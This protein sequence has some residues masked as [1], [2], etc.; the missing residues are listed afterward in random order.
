MFIVI[1]N[2]S[3]GEV[4]IAERR[5]VGRS[6]S[7]KTRA[8]VLSEVDEVMRP[9]WRRGFSC[10]M[11]LC[12]CTGGV[13][14]SSMLLPMSDHQPI[15]RGPGSFIKVY[16]DE[17]SPATLAADQRR[18]AVA[19]ALHSRLGEGSPLGSVDALVLHSV[20]CYAGLG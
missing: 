12:C 6:V 11:F 3:N 20:L 19:M 2:L 9:N 1:R 7:Q 10:N 16:I 8:L 5:V 18:L 15:F 14:S 4:F 17:K 13:N